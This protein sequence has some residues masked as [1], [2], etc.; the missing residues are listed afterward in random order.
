[1]ED[2]MNCQRRNREKEAEA[3]DTTSREEKEEL[4]E[5]KILLEG[6]Y[7]GEDYLS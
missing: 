7:V 6:S 1:M 3:A 4:D 2:A 5:L